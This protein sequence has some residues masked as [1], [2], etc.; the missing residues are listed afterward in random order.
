MKGLSMINYRK[1]ILALTF[2]TIFSATLISCKDNVRK[3]TAGPGKDNNAPISPDSPGTKKFLGL[4]DT[5]GKPL[6][7]FQKGENFNIKSI[8][9]GSPVTYAFTL[10]CNTQTGPIQN[11]LT[12]NPAAANCNGSSLQITATATYADTTTLSSPVI[13]IQPYSLKLLQ[14]PVS[15]TT[16]ECFTGSVKWVDATDKDII[17]TKNS[18]A[19][20]G[21]SG[22]EFYLDSNCSQ[23]LPNNTVIV[24]ST[25]SAPTF[26]VKGTQENSAAVITASSGNT[27]TSS[28][29]INISNLPTLM[30]T[31]SGNTLRDINFQNVPLKNTM[32]NNRCGEFTLSIN[33][34]LTEDMNVD[35]ISNSK[36]MVIATDNK[37]KKRINKLVIS[38]NTRSTVFYIGNLTPEEFSV[39]ASSRIKNIPITSSPF[40]ITTIGV[41]DFGGMYGYGLPNTFPNPGADPSNGLSCPS[42]YVATKILDTNN[43]DWPL[44][45]CTRNPVDFENSLFDFGGIWGLGGNYPNQA[46]SPAENKCPSGYNVLRTYGTTSKDYD[47][48]Y[49]YRNH[50]DSKQTDFYFSGMYGYINGGAVTIN[51]F[52]LA[53]NCNQNR[54]TKLPKFDGFLFAWHNDV[55]FA[56]SA[57]YV[58]VNQPK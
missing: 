36:N 45:M 54:L 19:L 29:G 13:T 52:N 18:I 1:T 47:I 35:M 55:D 24:S 26:Y 33:S 48:Y 7:G 53:P 49:C 14:L 2:F 30:I 50:L 9:D 16:N 37:C 15:A 39:T 44:Y 56:A 22:I 57:C 38:K 8:F 27:K 43:T 34:I 28:S 3:N 11:R 31:T 10:V 42:S 6:S 21:S 4:Q 5:L 32:A 17:P 40:V 51:P 20:N 46:V 25:N 23:D 12:T 41:L 58:G